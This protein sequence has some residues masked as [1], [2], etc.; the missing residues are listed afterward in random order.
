MARLDLPNPD[1]TALFLRYSTPTFPFWWVLM[2]SGL[3]L[4]LL[5]A[6]QRVAGWLRGVVLLNSAGATLLA[7][8]FI[9]S[10]LWTVQDLAFYY[11]AIDYPN[12]NFVAHERCLLAYPAQRD[13]TCLDRRRMHGG[14]EGERILRA[15]TY[16]VALFRQQGR[17]NVLPETYD[18]GAPLVLRMPSRWLSVYLREWA[19]AGVPEDALFHVAPEGEVFATAAMQNPPLRTAETFDPETLPQWPSSPAMPP[20]SG[21][22]PRQKPPLMTPCF[23]T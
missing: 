18:P 23:L 9:R 20:R 4:G 1:R 17:V 16:G 21:T 3:W 19:L 11:N 10:T 2:A 6:R 13:A 14:Y 12:L 7:F 22:S 15:A 5:A 8:L